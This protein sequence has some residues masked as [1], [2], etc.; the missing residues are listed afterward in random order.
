V[1]AYEWSSPLTDDELAAWFAFGPTL[2][3]IAE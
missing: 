2:H 3:P 1:R